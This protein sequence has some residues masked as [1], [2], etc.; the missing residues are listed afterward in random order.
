M[1]HMYFKSTLRLLF[2]E[3]H[4]ATCYKGTQRYNNNISS[5]SA[6][7]VPSSACGI[8]H[9]LLLVEITSFQKETSG[10]S[11]ED[12]NKYRRQCKGMGV[13]RWEPERAASGARVRLGCTHRRGNAFQGEKRH[14]QRLGI[15][16]VLAVWGKQTSVPGGGV[17]VE[18]LGEKG[19]WTRGS[20][21]VHGLNGGLR[22]ASSSWRT[23]K[24]AQEVELRVLILELKAT[25]PI[26]SLILGF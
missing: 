1:P 16:G 3:I 4:S 26:H 8:K 7:F 12:A 10:I 21:P 13:Q 23:G 6:S 2:S 24:A 18:K 5:H 20:W 15:R 9:G 11:R 25:L 19:D 17:P 14:R 22:A